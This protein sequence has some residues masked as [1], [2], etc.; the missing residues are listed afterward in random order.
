MV[1]SPGIEPGSKINPIVCSTR[2]S[3]AIHRRRLARSDHTGIH[4]VKFFSQYEHEK[5]RV[6]VTA[7]SVSATYADYFLHLGLRAIGGEELFDEHIARAI[8]YA[9]ART[10]VSSKMATLSTSSFCMF[11]VA[12]IMLCLR[13][14]SVFSIL[15][16]PVRPH[17]F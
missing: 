14:H 1:E 11:V 15:S 9:T 2:N 3:S 17:M 4:S 16:I 7:C 5:E 12:A 13:A 10:T 8:A 6:S